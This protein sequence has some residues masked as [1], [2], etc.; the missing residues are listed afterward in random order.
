MRHRIAHAA[1]V[2]Q[3][4]VLLKFCSIFRCD[5]EGCKFAEPGV[6]AVYGFIPRRRLG[7][8]VCGGL[9]T[10]AAGRIETHIGAVGEDCGEIC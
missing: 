9:H 5:L 8:A 4:Q 3:D 10:R 7:D 6:H 1:A 2:G